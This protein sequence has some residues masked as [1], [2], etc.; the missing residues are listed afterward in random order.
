MAMNKPKK[1][2]PNTWRPSSASS[3]GPKKRTPVKKVA[4]KTAAK[5]DYPNTWRPKSV[6]SEGPKRSAMRNSKKKK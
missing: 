3:E 2:Y 4:K 5:K 6:G 1:D